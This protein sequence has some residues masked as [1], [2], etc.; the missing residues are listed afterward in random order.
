MMASALFPMPCADLLYICTISFSEPRT[1]KNDARRMPQPVLHLQMISGQGSR[2]VG[3]TS[4]PWDDGTFFRFRIWIIR[5]LGGRGP[6]LA[7][8]HTQPSPSPPREASIPLGPES[9][10]PWLRP[11]VQ[12]TRLE[13]VAFDERIHSHA[14][15]G[16]RQRITHAMAS[17]GVRIDSTPRMNIFRPNLNFEG[18]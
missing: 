5:V 13:A 18:W 15:I 6:H 14:E 2:A 8:P 12:Q 10:Q 7:S 17:G 11:G 9:L 4:A 1:N 16:V 3:T